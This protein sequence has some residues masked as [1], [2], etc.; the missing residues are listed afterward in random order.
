[1][2]PNHPP[3]EAARRTEIAALAAVPATLVLFE[4][5]KRLPALLAALADTLGDREAAVCRELTKRFEEVRRGR[6]PDLAAAYAGEE[7]RGEVVVVVGRGTA[8][9]ASE[10]EVRARL[11]EALATMRLK[12]AATAVAGALGLPRQ[13]VYR[14]AL[15]MRDE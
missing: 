7:V 1:M 13:Q 9:A 4:S 6:L 3:A 8:E 11:R 2:D 12:D 14:L 10:E 15:G 5:P